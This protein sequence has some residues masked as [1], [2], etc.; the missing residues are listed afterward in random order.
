MFRT[1]DF[2]LLF[3]TIVFLVVAISAAVIDKKPQSSTTSGVK[4]VDS[5]ERV[6]TASTYKPES[7]SRADKL[8]EMKQKIAESGEII[9][10]ATD[11]SDE[12]VEVVEMENSDVVSTALKKCENYHEFLGEWSPQGVK[13][14]IVEGA[15]VIYR[16]S[17]MAKESIGT[18]SS[19]S[20][21]KI[22]RDTLLELPIYPILGLNSSCLSSD[23]IG[24]A[25]DG[26]L[27]R[28]NESGL[29]GIFGENTL[30]G[31]ALDGHSI[32]GKT[33]SI[34]DECGGIDLSNGYAYY[35]SSGSENILNCYKA[36]PSSI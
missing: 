17:P 4:F 25:Q 18:T 14:E 24:V 2:I 26:S 3:V 11:K 13:F 15:R 16:E 8:S 9:A 7:L 23:V 19:S 28:N 12:E 1:R 22:N 30:I 10:P 21:P 35:I 20:L 34:V 32:Y 6:Y 33:E 29:Y 36:N 5:G 31:Y 27:I